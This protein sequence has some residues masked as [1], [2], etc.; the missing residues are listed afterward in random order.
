MCD[1][2][3][4]GHQFLPIRLH[5]VF[6]F[7]ASAGDRTVEVVL[8]DSCNNSWFCYAKVK[9]RVVKAQPDDPRDKQGCMAW[10]K[11]FLKG[12]ISPETW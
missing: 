10:A 6:G 8:E 7:E 4:M 11:S 3:R 1:K 5:N 12:E 9:G 2:G